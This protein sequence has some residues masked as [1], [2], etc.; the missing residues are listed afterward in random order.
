MSNLRVPVQVERTTYDNLKV[1]ADA[2]GITQTAAIND[3]LADWLETVGAARMHNELSLN[4][5]GVIMRERLI[6]LSAIYN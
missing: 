4:Q 6:E 1:Y 5:H 2:M 3:A